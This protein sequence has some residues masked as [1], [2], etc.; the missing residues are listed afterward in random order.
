MT[1]NRR[2][3]AATLL[4]LASSLVWV[5]A[6]DV[7][8]RWTAKFSTQAGDQEYTY[9]FV[10]KGTALTGTAKGN[11]L[12]ETVISEGKVDGDKVSFVENA[13]FMDMPIRIEYTGTVSSNDEI[14]FT[15]KVADFATEEL[16]ARRAK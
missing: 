15:R 5:Y 12:G 4:L 9:D 6:A 7:T 3:V 8:G 11:L 10:V 13:K 2:A 14:K 1:M 16:V